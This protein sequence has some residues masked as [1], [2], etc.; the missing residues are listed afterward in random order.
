MSMPEPSVQSTTQPKSLQALASQIQMA[1]TK[2][3]DRGRFAELP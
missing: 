2:E 1:S 3:S